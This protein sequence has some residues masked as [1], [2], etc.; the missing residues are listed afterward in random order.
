MCYLE[1]HCSGSRDWGPLCLLVSGIT[2]DSMRSLSPG[3]KKASDK[4][5]YLMPS[6]VLTMYVQASMHTHVDTHIHD[7]FKCYTHARVHVHTHT[8]TNDIKVTKQSINKCMSA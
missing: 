6:S 5:G 4:A 1:A 8:H 3:K 2:L 7:P